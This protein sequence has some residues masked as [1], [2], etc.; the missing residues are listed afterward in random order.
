MTDRIKELEGDLED[1]PLSKPERRIEKSEKLNKAKQQLTEFKDD[2]L[3]LAVIK[4]NCLYKSFEFCNT[5]L[6]NRFW[7]VGDR[8]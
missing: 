7:C 4:A 5:K 6:K 2:V 3:R 8:V 1:I